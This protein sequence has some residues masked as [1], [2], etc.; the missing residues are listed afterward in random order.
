[1]S[2]ILII[3]GGVIGVCAAYYLTQRGAKVTLLEQGEI[4]NG[5]SYGNA[6]LIVPSHAI[7]LAASGV[8]TKGLAWM[9]N[10]E[11]PFYI[12]PRLDADLISWLIR[13]ALACNESQMHKAMPVMRDLGNASSALYQQL[14]QEFNFGYTRNGLLSVFFSERGYEEGLAEANLLNGIGITAEAVSAPHVRKQEPQLKNAI[15][16][17]FYP[18]DSHLIP[19]NFVRGLAQLSNARIITHCEALKIEANGNRIIKVKTTRGEFVADQF[20]LAGGAWSPLLSRD[21]NFNLPIQGAKGYSI[22]VKRPPFISD[23]PISLSESKVILTPMGETL[24]L[25]GTLELAGLDFRINTR[26]VNAILQ[27]AQ[28]YVNG[29]DTLEVIEIWRGLRPCSPDGL[30]IIGRAAF[31]NLI[32]ATGHAML[33]MSLGPITGKLVSEIVYHDISSLPLNALQPSRF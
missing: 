8:L 4:A 27:A 33:G 21:L 18:N 15:G 23:T 7:P 29:M 22:T 6:G 28:T 24:R 3:G 19:A 10:A 1:M 31:E 13:F 14:A 5:S 16:G 2:D 30:P 9:L 20:V 11:S 32:M 25:A 26:R 17:I 12:K